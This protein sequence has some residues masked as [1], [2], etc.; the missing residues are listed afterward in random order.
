MSISYKP[1]FVSSIMLD[2]KDQVNTDFLVSCWRLDFGV[3]TFINECGVVINL[4]EL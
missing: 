3:M 2:V 4:G 1:S